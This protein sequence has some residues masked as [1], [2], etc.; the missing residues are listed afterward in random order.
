MYVAPVL[1]DALARYWGKA[2]PEMAASGAAHHT[3]L[4][5]SLDVAACAFVLVARHPVLAGRLSESSGLPVAQLPLTIAAVCG[6]HDVGK[7]DTRFSRKAAVIADQLRPQ[8]AGIPSGRYDH[9]TEGFRQLERD[10]AAFGQLEGHLG[11]SAIPLLRA[12]TGHHGSLP[13]IDEP[14]PSRATIPRSL[15]LEDAT[16]RRLFVDLVCEF[17]GSLGAL[18]PWP[19]GVS[20]ET[21]Q[22]VAGLCA[23]S[24]WIGSDTQHFPYRPGPIVD[25]AAYWSES[26][27]RADVAC[28]AAGLLRATTSATAFELLF[29]GYVPRD[30]QILT[31]G[32]AGDEPALVIVEAEMGKGKT[33]AALSLAARFIK[34]QHAEGITVGLPTMATSN[35]MFARVEDFT[36]RLYSGE[37]VQIALAHSRASRQPR[38]YALVQRG[39][40]A[41][42]IDAAEASVSCARWLLNKKRVLLAQIGVGTIDQALQ[43]ALTVKHQFVRLFG[44][45]RN[46][47]II[48]EVHAYDAYMEVLLEHLLSW[49]GAM[50]VPVILLSAT[51][52]SARRAALAAAWRGSPASADEPDT[53]DVAEAR[54][55]P[56]VT[57]ASRSVT[58]TRSGV[59]SGPAR[60][61]YLERVEKADTEAHLRQIA[62]RLIVAARS[63]ARVAWVRNTV[64]EAQRAYAAVLDAAPDVEHVLF[65]ARFRG[66]DRRRIETHVLERFGKEAPPG[67]RLLIATQVIEQSL[68]LDFDELHTD[69]APIDLMFQRTGR[70]HRHVRPRPAGFESPRLVVHGPT[71]EDSA[72][73]NFGGSQYVYDVATLWIADR[74]IRSRSTLSLPDDIR[75]LVE[76]SY[77]PQLRQEQLRAGPDRLLAQEAALVAKL[78]G[79]RTKARR[80][81]IPPTTSD[82]EGGGAMDDDD[83]AV[84]AFTRDGTSS[85]VLP[86]LW[87][88]ERGR[89][90]GM[91]DDGLPWNLDAG[92]GAAWRLVGELMDQTLSI[93]SPVEPIV[94]RSDLAVWEAFRARFD[95]FAAETS[96]GKNVVPLPLRRDGEGFLGH[97]RQ[98]QQPRSIHYSFTLGLRVL[99]PDDRTSA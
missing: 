84:Q 66:A 79:K 85:T 76:Q 37:D 91:S 83:D 77:H 46:V 90:L 88:G 4:G 32:V 14:D 24:D 18:L 54:P 64:S 94:P 21:C 43:A 42:D 12:V 74:A 89:S 34:N 26:C 9:G 82:P 40:R 17:F 33:E 16:A 73:L 5:H 2:A 27:E 25:V 72:G 78:E 19:S 30:V 38:F 75:P 31:E 81:C 15:V 8:T 45:S 20:G 41:R 11:P 80:C 55:Y 59:A 95:R 22:R 58:T 44:L 71:D 68:D 10:D 87:D 13:T 65:H 49:L 51:L 70:L 86:F 93:V 48:D 52:P 63:G 7:L 6:L 1:A 67:G 3:V 29:P 50:Q 98:W 62:Q 28:G 57:I 61:I 96:F 99:R 97:G 36:P 23:I 92:D 69:V 35:A 60:T 47:V 53:A 39:L 56:L